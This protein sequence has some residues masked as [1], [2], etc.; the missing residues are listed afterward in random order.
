MLDLHCHSTCSDGALSPADLVARA[1]AIGLTALALTD[2]DTVD[3]IEAFLAAGTQARTETIPGVEVACMGERS[4]ILHIVGLWMDVHDPALTA[5]LAR[6]R[7]DRL[8]RN[9]DMVARLRALGCQIELADV[10]AAAGGAVVGR[11][12]IARA[13]V[14]SGSCRSIADAFGLYLGRGKPGYVLRV[15]P[16]VE[17]A[18]GVLDRAGAVTVWAH[19]LTSRSITGVGLRRIARHLASLGL[20]GI[21]VFYSD[22]TAN[23]VEVAR[24]CARDVGL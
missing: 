12:H 22:Y 18:L 14:N 24:K 10:V 3:G 17:E 15:L 5:L 16:S 19:A 8:D 23:Q 11:P 7:R 1:D 2:H 4:R 21:E 6:V 13:L 20:D 9:R